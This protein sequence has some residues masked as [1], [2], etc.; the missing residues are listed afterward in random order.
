M[1]RYQVLRDTID[2]ATGI[3]HKAGT[4]WE[5]D[6]PVYVE[7]DLMGNPTGKEAPMKVGTNLKLIEEEAKPA[8]KSK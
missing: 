8:V 2:S 6:L 1:A 3:V 7:R 5:L 4:E